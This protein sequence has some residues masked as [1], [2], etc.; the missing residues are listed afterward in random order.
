MLELTT[1]SMHAI[2]IMLHGANDQVFA[3]TGLVR[4]TLR[5][6]VRCCFSFWLSCLDEWNSARAFLYS[7]LGMSMLTGLVLSRSTLTVL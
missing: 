6:L 2:E 3:G 4:I 5:I 7:G 1:R